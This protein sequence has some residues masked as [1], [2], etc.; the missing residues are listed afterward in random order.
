M[1]VELWHISRIIL[2]KSQNNKSV[3][4]SIK[5]KGRSAENEM[6]S[7]IWLCLLLEVL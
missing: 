4:L 3:V 1:C 5:P 7:N 6:C 2:L